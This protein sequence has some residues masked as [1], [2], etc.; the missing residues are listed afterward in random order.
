M[1]VVR[2]CDMRDPLSRAEHVAAAVMNNST[3]DA[4]APMVTAVVDWEHTRLSR[5]KPPLPLRV[6]THCKGAAD[7]S[8]ILLGV[9][10][11]E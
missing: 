1:R 11:H 9:G 2:P 10:L 7:M 8:V 4:D 5:P 6:N 3:Q